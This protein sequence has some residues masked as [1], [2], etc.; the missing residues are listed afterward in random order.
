MATK[1][2]TTKIGLTFGGEIL[3]G[4]KIFRTANNIDPINRAF[5]GLKKPNESIATEIKL[6]AIIQPR[7]TS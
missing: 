2:I 3:R 5:I 1:I 6:T 4:N 7:N